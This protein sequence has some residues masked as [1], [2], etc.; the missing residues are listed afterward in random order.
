M[1]IAV[2]SAAMRHSW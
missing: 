2:K 1:D